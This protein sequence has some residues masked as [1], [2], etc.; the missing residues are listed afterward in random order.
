MSSTVASLQSWVVDTIYWSLVSVYSLTGA[1]VGVAHG[2]VH[3]VQALAPRLTS[4]QGIKK[5]VSGEKAAHDCALTGSAIGGPKTHLTKENGFSGKPEGLKA[6]HGTDTPIGYD[7]KPASVAPATPPPT[8]PPT[9]AAPALN[10]VDLDA[11]FYTGVSPPLPEA[12]HPPS[13]PAPVAAAPVRTH[14]APV[15]IAHNGIAKAPPAVHVPGDGWESASS[16][17]P[18]HET[19]E[20]SAPASLGSSPRSE[21][22]GEHHVKHPHAHKAKKGIKKLGAKI[23]KAFNPHGDATTP[24]A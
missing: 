24:T 20:D 15:P 16:V 18:G 5:L 19:G 14:A 13:Y 8:Q 4:V 1:L 22:N 2:S 3:G 12:V 7:I 21:A 17:T 6:H 10:P 11:A 9:P 23:K